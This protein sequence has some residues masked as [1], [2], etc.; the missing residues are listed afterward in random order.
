MPIRSLDHKLVVKLKLVSW[1][2]KVQASALQTF[3]DV[4]VSQI[5]ST[6]YFSTEDSA[7]WVSIKNNTLTLAAIS[8]KKV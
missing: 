8:L 3:A 4:F 2:A 7:L 5:K 6:K 1:Q